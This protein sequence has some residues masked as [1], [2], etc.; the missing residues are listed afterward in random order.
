MSADAIFAV[1]MSLHDAVQRNAYLEQ[2]C[3]KDAELRQKVEQLLQAHGGGSLI[4]Q[5]VL[6][7]NATTVQSLPLSSESHS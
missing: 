3:G 6:N 5:V 4:D 1:A 7:L 2:A